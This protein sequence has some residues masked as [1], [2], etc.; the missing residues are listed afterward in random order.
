MIIEIS[1]MESKEAIIIARSTRYQFMQAS[2]YL[3]LG[4]NEDLRITSKS[5]EPP[6]RRIV[7]TAGHNLNLGIYL[8]D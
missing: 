2:T 8:I 7:G 4:W 1:N 6:P 3:T 5:R